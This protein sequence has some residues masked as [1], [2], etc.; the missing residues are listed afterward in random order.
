VYTIH[1]SRALVALV[2]SVGGILLSAQDGESKM[3]KDMVRSNSQQI[4]GKGMGI[5][6][7]TAQR[8][9]A[10]DAAFWQ[11]RDIPRE[12]RESSFSGALPLI[13]VHERVTSFRD[14]VK[15]ASGWQVYG[16]AVPAGGRI[17]WTL[18]QPR[19]GWFRFLVVDADGAV[20]SGQIGAVTPGSRPMAG[21]NNERSRPT[22]AYLLVD[23]PGR[24]SSATALF[25]ISVNRSWET[26][27]ADL[28]GA[29]FSR[30][31]W[32]AIPGIA[33]N[34]PAAQPGANPP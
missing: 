1:C 20:L 11:K 16:F 17:Q 9:E 2:A 7:A 30:G 24:I 6:R 22:V 33:E 29:R 18:T 31:V 23:D 26:G 10:P 3:P 19:E 13:P 12:I 8:T 5:P 21:F 4:P 14:F 32:G 34:S 27:K 25:E 15:F 28:S